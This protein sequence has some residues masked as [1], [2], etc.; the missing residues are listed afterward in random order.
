M[1]LEYAKSISDTSASH[2]LKMGTVA[3]MATEVAVTKHER[4]SLGRASKRLNYTQ[5]ALDLLRQRQA[6]KISPPP[7]PPL[8]PFWHNPLHDMESIWWLCIWMMFYLVPAESSV[9]EHFANYCGLFKDPSP[10]T[11]YNFIS[12]QDVY[13]SLTTH[14]PKSFGSIMEVW[15]ELLN[16]HYSMCYEKHDASGTRNNSI[17][18]D[19]T[20]V[21]GSYED[22]QK[23]IEKL[24]NEASNFP[25][26][27]VTL[28]ERIKVIDGREATPNSL[29]T[30][31]SSPIFDCVE[32]PAPKS[33]RREATAYN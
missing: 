31:K 21:K 17:C 13:R 24:A 3:F 33:R 26:H 9:R 5:E 16:C 18:V 22:G 8:P 23:S 30:A 25:S 7:I 28:T 20:T 27:L 32:F 12:R 14:L 4:L 10:G 19:S 1:D 15:S 6:G 11:K 2:D 29:V